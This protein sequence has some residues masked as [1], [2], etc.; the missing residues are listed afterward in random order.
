MLVPAVVVFP[1]VVWSATL[2]AVTSFATARLSW[3]CVFNKRRH[4]PATEEARSS[5][6]V[7]SACIAH[8]TKGAA[9]ATDVHP[10]QLVKH[11]ICRAVFRPQLLSGAHICQAGHAGVVPEPHMH[12][13]HG[14]TAR[15]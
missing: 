15:W 12:H 5:R 9:R 8:S 4:Q 6:L 1:A 2:S 13:S 11:S 14:L 10:L 7:L 3:A